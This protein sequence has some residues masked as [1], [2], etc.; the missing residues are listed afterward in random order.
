[1]F[2][3]E[4]DLAL[5]DRGWDATQQTSENIFQNNY[6]HRARSNVIF[7]SADEFP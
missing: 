3:W 2:C 5:L 6:G 4:N 7:K 1:M